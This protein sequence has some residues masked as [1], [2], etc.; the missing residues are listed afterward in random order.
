MAIEGRG[1]AVGQAVGGFSLD[2]HPL[3]FYDRRILAVVY[4]REAA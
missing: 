1:Q 2:N 3:A 4:R